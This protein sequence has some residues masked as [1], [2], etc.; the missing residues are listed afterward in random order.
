M[1]ITVCGLF[2]AGDTNAQD[3]TIEFA[4]FKVGFIVGAGGGTGTLTY[5]GKSYPLRVGGVSLGATIGASRAELVGNVYNLSKPE[6]IE[7]TYTA[8]AGSA[9][10]AGGGSV[11]NLQNSKG[12]SLSVSGRSI[13]LEFS[14]NLSGLRIS[15][16]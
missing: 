1:V 5:Q 11:A 8:A 2:P 12:V 10:L 9:V 4:V 16:R 15:L 6:D 13:G 3:A 7:G 14:L